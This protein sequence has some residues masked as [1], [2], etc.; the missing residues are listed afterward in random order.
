MR[1]WF[2]KG[3]KDLMVISVIVGGYYPLKQSC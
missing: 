3:V 1:L 2:Y